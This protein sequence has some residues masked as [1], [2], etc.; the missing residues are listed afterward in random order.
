MSKTKK[1]TLKEKVEVYES[2]L[3]RINFHRSITMNEKAITKL[4][5]LAD[6]W[7][8]AHQLISSEGGLKE[9]EERVNGAFDKLRSLP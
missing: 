9:Q 1:P 7:S 8:H 4:L 6:A 5:D 3:H 2:F